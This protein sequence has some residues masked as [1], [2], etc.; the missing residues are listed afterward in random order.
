MRLPQHFRAM[1]KLPTHLTDNAKQALL[2][3]DSD[4]IRYVRG[5]RWI[6]Y[7]QAEAILTKLEDL[8]D[9]PKTHRMPNLLIEGETNSGKTMII[10]RFKS[11]HPSCD[12]EEGEAISCPVL[13]VQSP[14]VPDEGRLYNQILEGIYAP[15]QKGDC[16]DAKLFQLIRLLEQIG[17][18][19]LVIDEIHDMLA[20]PEK[21]RHQVLNAV[22]FL[23]NRL[24]IVIVAVGTER[25]AN[26]FQ[27]DPQLTN[28]FR[29]ML[30]PKWERV[31]TPGKIA[32][33]GLLQ[34]FEKTLP[35]WKPS[36]L[37][38]DQ[39]ANKLLIMSEGLIGEL[40][41][42]LAEASIT[43]IKSKS[44]RITLKILKEL[45]WVQPS[46]RKQRQ[47]THVA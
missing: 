37:S 9:H 30:L 26:V 38:Q 33:N 14:P 4:R 43:A 39:L 47:Q 28:R 32:F 22:K 31:T 40:S 16:P 45:D 36:D 1:N 44:E 17:T 25:A 20:G 24:K 29:R 11:L 41:T 18:K 6:G 3:S 5:V 27:S 19:I 21:K 13:V 42:I 46:A 2:K 7:K 15:Y 8:F 12:N 34:R 35:L 10:E 23:G